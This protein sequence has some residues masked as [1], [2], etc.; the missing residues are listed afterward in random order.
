MTLHQ[1]GCET[2]ERSVSLR[3]FALFFSLLFVCGIA[4]AH[5]LPLDF[6]DEMT[7]ISFCRN[8]VCR[9]DSDETTLHG[10]LC[11]VFCVAETTCEDL[12]GVPPPIP[13][14][15]PPTCDSDTPPPEC[16]ALQF[17]G[18]KYFS[19]KQASDTP[20]IVGI[21]E[22]IMGIVSAFGVTVVPI[23]LDITENVFGLFRGDFTIGDFPAGLFS[24]VAGALTDEFNHF[25]LSLAYGSG[26][27]QGTFVDVP[28]GNEEFILELKCNADIENPIEPRF[29]CPFAGRAILV[30][31]VE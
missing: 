26:D 24:N 29:K 21:W 11:W 2:R 8:E 7:I 16:D 17:D 18:L 6:C 12:A 5:P 1:L 4:Y 20:Q 22:G 15:E 30:R 9:E 23:E 31:Q 13:D 25:S 14:P 19:L 3:H 10:P 27:G 28:P